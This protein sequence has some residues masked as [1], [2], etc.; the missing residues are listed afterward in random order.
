MTEGMEHRRMGLAIAQ[1]EP[2]VWEGTS[3]GVIL[4]LVPFLVWFTRRFPIH[5]DTW[6]SHLPLYVVAS[7]IWSLLHVTLMVAMRKLIYLSVGEFYDFG[8]WPRELIYEYLKDAR[9]FLGMVMIIIGWRWAKRRL[10]GEAR[11][12]DSPEVGKAHDSIERPERFLVRK[13]NREFL[14]AVKE[15]EW[16]QASGNYVNLHL[17][18]RDYP[19]RSTLSDL[20]SRLDPNVFTRVHRSYIVNLNYILSIEPNDSGDAVLHMQNGR[21][22]PCSRRYREALRERVQKT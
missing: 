6:R 8:S 12:L 20:E 5:W 2:W 7:I 1:W 17:D 3:N 22:I 13:L 18:Q 19:L 16:L 4:V 21:A 10:Q 11:L 9:S 15:I 14:V